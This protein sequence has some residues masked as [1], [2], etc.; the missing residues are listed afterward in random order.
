MQQQMRNQSSEWSQCLIISC[1]HPFLYDTGSE[2]SPM[3]HLT[4]KKVMKFIYDEKI[5]GELGTSGVQFQW[6]SQ[7]PSH[8]I[9]RVWTALYTLRNSWLDFTHCWRSCMI[10]C[11]HTNLADIF[12]M[13][14]CSSFKV[15]HVVDIRFITYIVLSSFCSRIYIIISCVI[16]C[17]LC[18]IFHYSPIYNPPHYII[19][20]S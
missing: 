20:I 11:L 12:D 4:I 16:V 5:R 19:P 9:K 18:F 6:W 15:C 1:M 3:M 10:R 2:N 14:K 13:P 17:Y 8:F 7:F